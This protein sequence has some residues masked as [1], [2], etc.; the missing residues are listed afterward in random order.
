MQNPHLYHRTN[1]LFS[2]QVELTEQ[3]TFGD[4]FRRISKL[5]IPHLYHRASI[6]LFRQVEL[7]EKLT[8]GDGFAEDFKVAKSPPLPQGE[9][10]L[11]SA[12]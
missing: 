10:L 7:T 11:F 2:I 6:F 9:R 1:V 4:G 8:F 3:L 12:G 5:Q